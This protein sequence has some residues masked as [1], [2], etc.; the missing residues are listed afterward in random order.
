LVDYEITPLFPQFGRAAYSLPDDKRQETSITDFKGHVVEAFKLRSLATKVG[1]TR[2]PTEDGGWFFSYEKLFPGI[3]FKVKLEFSGNGL[4]EENRS[5]AL[6]KMSFI[7]SNVDSEE[8][9]SE[10]DGSA[11][12]DVPSVLLT[13]CYNDLAAIAASGSGFDPEWE[14]KVY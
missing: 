8:S 1:Y 11:L 13:E 6:V 14:K 2:G 7:A 3:G 12:A 10:A 5:V 4:P 9:F